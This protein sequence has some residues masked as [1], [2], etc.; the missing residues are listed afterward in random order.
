MQEDLRQQVLQR[1]QADYGLKERPGTEYMRGGRCPSCGKKELYANH[2]KPWVV[3]CGRQAKCGRELHVKDLYDDLFDDWG[4]RFAPTPEAPNAAADAYLQ[5]ARGFDLKHVRGLYTQENYFDPR[6]RQGSTT[7]RFPLAKGEWWERL[8]DRAHRFGKMKARFKP[9]GSFAGVWWATP[10]VEKQLETAREVWIVEGIFDAIA[11]LH[12]GNVAVSAMSSNQFP[13]QSLRELAKR[14]A[15]DL[16]TLIWAPDNEPAKGNAPGTHDYLRKHV[17][18]A[19]AMG[20]TCKAALIPQ[21]AGRK[22][23]WNDLHL[24]STA[25]ASSVDQQQQWLDDMAAAR[26][27]GDLLLAR[28]ALEKGLL[29]FNHG[30]RRQFHLEYRSRLYWFE[31]DTSRFN[32]VKEEDAKTNGKDDQ[33]ERLGELQAH[34]AQVKEISNCYPEALYYQR[35]EVTDEAWYF[36]RVDFP[37]DSPPVKGTFTSSQTLNAPAFRDRL[38]SVARGAVFDG[39]ATEL[40][41]VMKDQLFNIKEVKAIDFVG[42]SREHQAY[43]FGDIAVRQGELVMANEEDYFEFD[44]VRLKTTQ[45]SIRMDIQRDPEGYR[46]DWLPWLWQCFG[47]HGVVALVFFFGS[48]FAEQIR[49]GH[50]SY[51]FLEAT[52]EAGAGKTTL[53]TFLWKLLGRTDY[54]GFDPAKSSKAGRARAMGQISNMPS[55]LLEADRSQPDKA[56]AKTFEWDE[57]KD[58]FGGGTLATRG[59]RN[60]GND[61]YEPPFRGTIVISQNAAV[62]ASEAILTRIVKLHFKRPQV[63]T[64]SRIAADNLNA[65]PVEALSHFLVKA[66]RAEKAVLDKFA[67]RVRFFEDALRERKEIRMERVIKNHAQ[68]LALLDCLRLVVDLPVPMI[69]ETRTALVNMAL[70]RQTAIHAD[71]PQVTEFWEVYEY[72]EGMSD[73]AVVNHSRDPNHIAINLNEFAAKAAHH[74]QRIADLPS[75]REL[76]RNSR[77]HKFLDANRAVNSAIRGADDADLRPQIIKCWVFKK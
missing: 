12:H 74:A 40:I 3:R 27:Q 39:T 24:R 48:L 20:F 69:E 57:L 16:P 43:L 70:E 15:N 59:V 22:V 34:A 17:A 37:F 7:V 5:A 64:E 45:K 77:R 62:D 38:A 4:K 13:E 41:H 63:T 46:T 1:L 68:M 55:V 19:R 52:G 66:I 36:F 54:E 60:G 23:D 53:L 30:H 72:L 47:T 42:Y 18:R 58:F 61:T 56:H 26:H 49:A 9:G 75:L 33:D 28:S 32:K 71:H 14:R 31:F 11:H 8:I 35:N 51:P 10:A 67:E 21:P 2:V 73:K 29:M 50:K 25:Q 76:L 44:K 6:L 65:L